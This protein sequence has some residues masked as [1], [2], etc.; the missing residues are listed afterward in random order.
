MKKLMIILAMVFVL[1]AC[2]GTGAESESVPDDSTVQ[3]PEFVQVCDVE[4]IL[5]IEKVRIFENLGI[6]MDFVEKTK[7]GK[8]YIRL[9]RNDK[10]LLLEYDSANPITLNYWGGNVVVVNSEGLVYYYG[11]SFTYMDTIKVTDFEGEIIDAIPH[12]HGFMALYIEG[13]EYGFAKFRASGGFMYRLPLELDEDNPV[14]DARGVPKSRTFLTYLDKD[15]YVNDQSQKQLMFV[16]ELGLDHTGSYNSFIYNLSDKSVYYPDIIVRNTDSGEKVMIIAAKDD[17]FGDNLDTDI[18]AKAVKLKDG[19][20][21][22]YV[23]FDAKYLKNGDFDFAGVEMVSKDK[24]TVEFYSEYLNQKLTVDFKAKKVNLT[25]IPQRIAENNLKSEI[26]VSSDGRYSLWW[27]DGGSGGDVTVMEI[28]LLD[29]QTDKVK[30]LDTI[31]G[32][33]GGNSDCGFF[34]NGDIYTIMLDEFKVFTTDMSQQG[35]VFEMSKNFPLG[36]N[37]VGQGTYRDLLSAR[38]DPVTH[39]WT[40]LYNEGESHEMYKDYFVD[41]DKFSDNFY[42]STYKVGILDPQGNLTKVYDTGE[43]VMSYSF[44]QIKMHMEAG[45]ILYFSV[46]FKGYDP[47]LEGKIDLKTGEY[48]NISGGYNEWK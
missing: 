18:S 27:A 34:S 46:L 47:Q 33:Y 2:T 37:A 15:I 7:N 40:V 43:Y 44:R 16:S 9:T 31:G 6:N 48:T 24:N 38:R 39:S 14:V 1:T 21:T 13:D 36:D 11:D 3:Q 17:R 35:P 20:P 19:N 45:D 5:N 12:G 28:Y 29:N 8:Q 30:Y 42:K 4:E 23:E 10:E 32:M 25:K 22:G 26:A 41:Y